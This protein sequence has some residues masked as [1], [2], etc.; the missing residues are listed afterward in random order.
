MKKWA[1]EERQFYIEAGHQGHERE[2]Y[3]ILNYFC[4]KKRDKQR[5]INLFREINVE[6]L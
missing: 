2:L 6:C 5:K 1:M 3:V 4:Q